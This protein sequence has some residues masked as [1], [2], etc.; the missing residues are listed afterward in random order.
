MRAPVAEDVHG[1]AVVQPVYGGAVGVAVDEDARAGILQGGAD[2]GGVGVGD[3]RAFAAGARLALCAQ[4][5]GD[6]AA[7]RA[8]QAVVKPLQEAAAQ[9]AAQALVAAVVVA[10]EV[11]VFDKDGM[12]AEGEG[13]P[14]GE[15]AQACGLGVGGAEEEVAVAVLVVQRA[16]QRGEGGGD[17]LLVGGGEVVAEPVVV[18]V[19]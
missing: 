8:R 15:D 5:F 11:A 3:A 10:E 9:D 19:A 17:A 14:F 7:Q 13:V 18:E 6:A 12:A 16:R 1:V 2:G 4:F